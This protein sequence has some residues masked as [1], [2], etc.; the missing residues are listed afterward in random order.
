MAHS[1]RFGALA[2]FIAA[3]SL[4]VTPAQAAAPLAPGGSSIHSGIPAASHGVAVEA[5]RYDRYH[6]YHRY[7]RHR[8]HND[9]IDAG[10]VFAGVL[11]LGGIAAI[12]SA[13]SKKDEPRYE[14]RRYED[15]TYNDRRTNPRASNLSGI[16]SAVSQCL[17]EIER[18]VR[19]EGVDN[20]SRTASGW[21]VS[22]TLFN[23][24][25]FT[26]QID[27]S[28]RI[29]DI[30]YGGYSGAAAGAED[31]QWSDDRYADARAAMG[32]SDYAASPDP[33]PVYAGTDVAQADTALPAYPGGPLP[34][35][36]WSED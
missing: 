14:D 28:G 19:V 35:E 13:A 24:N 31:G 18:D 3:A 32:Q 27:N 9:G 10:D 15:R 4:G 2:G 30:D 12:A 11:I 16:D 29:S 5:A 23:G 20:A 1:I 36:D 7:N 22:G 17:A 34:G 26:C 25:G 6:R 33:A 8:R 21:S